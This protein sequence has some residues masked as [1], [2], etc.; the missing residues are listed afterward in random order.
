VPVKS[1]ALFEDP[2]NSVCLSFW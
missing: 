1:I 2:E